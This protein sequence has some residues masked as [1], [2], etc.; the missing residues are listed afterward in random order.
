MNVARAFA[1]SVDLFHTIEISD[2]TLKKWTDD[3]L[4]QVVREILY[5]L[6]FG[7]VKYKKNAKRLQGRI[8][9]HQKVC[10]D[11]ANAGETSLREIKSVNRLIGRGSYYSGQQWP[12]VVRKLK[13]MA[14][15]SM[16]NVYSF[17]ERYPQVAKPANGMMG[18]P[19]DVNA[20]RL[21]D[22]VDGRGEIDGPKYARF[23]RKKIAYF[24]IKEGRP[25]PV[26][27]L[28]AVMAWEGAGGKV[29]RGFARM[30]AG[31]PY[32]VLS[33]HAF[34][35]NGSS[36]VTFREFVYEQ[37]AT[38][39]EKMVGARLPD[40]LRDEF[41]RK[42]ADE[43]T[44]RDI[45][46]YSAYPAQLDAGKPTGTP[47]ACKYL[48]MAKNSRMFEAKYDFVPVIHPPL[49][50]W[51]FGWKMSRE[52]ADELTRD[53]DRRDKPSLDLAFGCVQE[54]SPTVMDAEAFSSSAMDILLTV[55]KW[56]YMSMHRNVHDIIVSS[57]WNFF[58][59]NVQAFVLFLKKRHDLRVPNG[60]GKILEQVLV[61]IG[62]QGKSPL[63]LK[64]LRNPLSREL[65][66]DAVG[67]I[68]KLGV[69]E[70]PVEHALEILL[71]FQNNV[72]YLRAFPEE[73]LAIPLDEKLRFLRRKNDPFPEEGID[74]RKEDIR[75]SER[76]MKANIPQ[77]PLG[78]FLT[79]CKLAAHPPNTLYVQLFLKMKEV[80]IFTG[81]RLE[82]D[83]V[84]KLLFYDFPIIQFR[85]MLDVF[86]EERKALIRFFSKN[87]SA[88]FPIESRERIGEAIAEFVLFYSKKIK[89]VDDSRAREHFSALIH[90]VQSGLVCTAPR[91]LTSVMALGP[92]EGSDHRFV[93]F[94]SDEGG[95]RMICAGWRMGESNRP[96]FDVHLVRME[97]FRSS[98]ISVPFSVELP[99]EP[100]LFKYLGALGNY[101]LAEFG[102]DPEPEIPERF[103][104]LKPA[105]EAW[106]LELKSHFRRAILEM[107]TQ[108]P[109][110][111]GPKDGAFSLFPKD[112]EHFTFLETFDGR[113]VDS[114][115]FTQGIATSLESSNPLQILLAMPNEGPSI[116]ETE[117]EWQ[118]VEE[119][120]RWSVSAKGM[121]LN[122]VFP[123]EWMKTPEQKKRALN[124]QVT[125]LKALVFSAK[126]SG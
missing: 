99:D 32:A 83:L 24:Q 89:T 65:L 3:Q 37:T 120:V 21:M 12:D 64:A 116:I 33:Q 76:L 71:N 72:L 11:V 8:A 92:Y 110:T 59:W 93:P 60:Y 79:L 31:L 66:A 6:P 124:W 52:V 95:D 44:R 102:E 111:I 97:D 113:E 84:A 68:G 112:K 109:F 1:K 35:G 91:P 123:E 10:F 86:I 39:F 70:I 15:L 94:G 16:D 58:E 119:G 7:A 87:R 62:A 27:W 5:Y 101:H 82:R 106:I 108:K 14:A 40:G 2:R 100:E 23:L 114:R 50:K 69:T 75:L 78:T 51:L 36:D 48:T 125:C 57:Q 88:E 25:V 19:A 55:A 28:Q 67:C 45:V 118:P 121:R 63:F 9:L 117:V 90:H 54:F 53:L 42:M 103:Q 126:D 122:V 104:S 34:L 105:I 20:D 22:Y 81:C 43:R 13:G 115:D 41:K 4:D 29:V 17:P 30:L 38:S 77:G 49:L 80:Q 98:G 85:K 56:P 96:I 73:F 18:E 61:E 26:P 107:A 47:D 74:D 46:F